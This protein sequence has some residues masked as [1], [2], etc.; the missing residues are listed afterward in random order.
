MVW[1]EVAVKCIHVHEAATR[2]VVVVFEAGAC[3]TGF[4]SHPPESVG[5]NHPPPPSQSPSQGRVLAV[6]YFKQ[7]TRKN[8]FKKLQKREKQ[9]GALA[10]NGSESNTRTWPIQAPENPRHRRRKTK[11]RNGWRGRNWGNMGTGNWGL[12]TGEAQIPVPKTVFLCNLNNLMDF[13]EQ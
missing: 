2:A 13:Y 4:A 3:L 11:I 5:G 9:G 1:P 8:S 6:L 10:R 7:P 12:E